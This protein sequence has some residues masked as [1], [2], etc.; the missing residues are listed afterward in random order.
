MLCLSLYGIYLSPGQAWS[1]SS[2]PV[3]SIIVMGIDLTDLL[4][5]IVKNSFI[6]GANTYT[7]R[8]GEPDN[9]EIILGKA[10]V[11]GNWGWLLDRRLDQI[12][13][14]PTRLSL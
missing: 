14:V 1:T 9:G 10:T 12:P 7:L 3:I 4:G 13:F 6:S 2:L 11:D 5:E 8:A